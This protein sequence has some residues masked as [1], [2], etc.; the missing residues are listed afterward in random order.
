PTRTRA[1]ILIDTQP[2]TDDPAKTAGYDQLIEAWTA[3][4]GPPQE[5]KDT[6]GQIILGPGCDDA[7]RWMDAAA[8]IP[9]PT[10]R[11]VYET[12]VTRE[13]DVAPRIKELTMPALVVHGDADLAI[14]LDAGRWLAEQLPDAEL[15]VVE[16][17]GHAANLTHPQA[18][19]PAIEAFLARIS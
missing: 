6:V 2:G 16:G 8:A 4:G 18:V 10:V 3:P 17:A 15:V 19:N 11:Q 9:G 5:I 7:A 1:L 13:D 12:L 14:D